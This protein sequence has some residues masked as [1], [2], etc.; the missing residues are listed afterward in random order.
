MQYSKREDNMRKIPVTIGFLLSFCVLFLTGSRS[1]G[2]DTAIS[3]DTQT[4]LEC[5]TVLHPGIVEDWKRSR[6]AVSTPAMGLKKGPLEKR[7]SGDK[8]PEALAD[9]VVGCAECH[10]MNPDQHKDTFEHNDYHVHPVV[11]PGDCSVCHPVEDK[12]YRGNL[13]SHAYGNLMDNPLYRS[14]VDSVNGIHSFEGQELIQ[15][16][17]DSDTDADS[18]LYC[19]G[20]VVKAE[21]MRTV[22]TEYGE[23]SFPL[24]SGWPN[25]GVGRINPDGTRGSCSACHTRHRF[26]IEVARKPYTC[27]ECHKGPDVPAYSVYSVSKH[28]NIFHSKGGDWNFEA[29]PWTPG[30]DFTAPTCATCHVSLIVSPEE[31]I[32]ANR[33]HKMNDRLPW[34][35]FGLIY[36]HSHPKSPDTTLIRNRAGLSIPTELTGEQADQYLIGKDE[37]EKRK[38]TME[39]VCL[40]CHSLNWVEGHF[41]RFENTLRTT[42]RSTLAATEILS[43]AWDKGIAKGLAQG[44]SIFNEAIEKKWVEHWL[45]YANST[46]FASAMAG[47]DYGT[48]ANGRWYM[49]KNIQEM[50]EFLKIR[51]NF[52][53]SGLK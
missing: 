24:L 29:V 10:T 36:A 42:N 6:H 40:S 4:C 30:R 34:R 48:F 3:E 12:E 47:A 11:T 13:M 26:P 20:T 31:E 17:P 23:M 14:L 33:T 37:Q 1:F 41:T 27:S 8:F 9:H 28:G 35:I 21:G 15:K 5:H 49:S 22:E 53:S 18:C 7:I 43:S 52:K 16:P 19:H 32:I 39:K 46:R 38:K 44:D 45:F 2:D 51:L 25:Q 50:V